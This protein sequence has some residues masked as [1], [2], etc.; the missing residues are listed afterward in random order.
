[1]RHISN[2]PRATEYFGVKAAKE[3]ERKLKGRRHA[4]VFALRGPLGGGKTTC[5][6]GIFKALGVRA[7]AASPTFVLVRRFALPRR[8]SLYHIDL[9]RLEGRRAAGAL[10]IKK[11]FASPRHVA[12]VEW[13]QRASRLLP[14]DAVRISFRHGRGARERVIMVEYGN[15]QRR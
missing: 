6:R 8:R 2:S 14:R 13:A 9:Y 4:L 7:R 11:I 5:A 1:M 12:V 3:A 10:G 15:E